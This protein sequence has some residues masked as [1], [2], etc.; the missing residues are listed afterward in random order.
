[1]SDAFQHWVELCGM[2]SGFNDMNCE[3][4]GKYPPPAAAKPPPAPVKAPPGSDVGAG[5]PSCKDYE[6]DSLRCNQKVT[7]F[8]FDNQRQALQDER[9]AALKAC[10]QTMCNTL[11]GGNVYE[12]VSVEVSLGRGPPVG[13]VL[14]SQR[15][16]LTRSSRLACWLIPMH[17]LLALPSLLLWHPTSAMTSAP[18]MMFVHVGRWHVGL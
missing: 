8:G 3:I 16:M 11:G 17:L 9:D 13:C 12:Q 4:A 15:L 14:Q 6:A 7:A 1:M 5:L 18:M 2:P 10:A